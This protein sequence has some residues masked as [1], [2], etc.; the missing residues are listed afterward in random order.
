MFTIS[1]KR[2]RR[3]AVVQH[4]TVNAQVVLLC[5][6]L[7]IHFPALGCRM[8]HWVSSLN[9]LKIWWKEW[10]SVLIFHYYWLLFYLQYFYIIMAGIYGFPVVGINYFKFCHIKHTISQIHMES[11]ECTKFSPSTLLYE[12]SPFTLS[13]ATMFKCKLLYIL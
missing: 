3:G 10:K 8:R 9:I 12:K 1:L 6:L 5:I 7:Y 11:R 2:G 13:F 4:L